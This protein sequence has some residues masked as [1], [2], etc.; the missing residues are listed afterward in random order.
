MRRKNEKILAGS[1]EECR[2]DEEAEGMR[3]SCGGAVAN[4]RIVLESVRLQE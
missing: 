4:K 3:D 1:E 2:L